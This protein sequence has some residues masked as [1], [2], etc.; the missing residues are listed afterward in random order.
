MNAHVFLLPAGVPAGFRLVR[1][2]AVKHPAD[3][4]RGALLR[5]ARTGVYV[6]HAA[7]VNRS[8]PQSW[9]RALDPEA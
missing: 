9:A 7:G 8:A 4:G 6:I 5:N 1:A 3:D 2:A